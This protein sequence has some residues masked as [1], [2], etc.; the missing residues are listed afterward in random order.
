MQYANIF[1]PTF[2]NPIKKPYIYYDFEIKINKT[3]KTIS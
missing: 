3:L 1:P 2:D